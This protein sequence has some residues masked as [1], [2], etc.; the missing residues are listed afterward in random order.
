[1]FV[2]DRRVSLVLLANET[3]KMVSAHPLSRTL[4]VV[5]FLGALMESHC[6]LDLPLG[7]DKIF[8]LYGGARSHVTHHSRFTCN[9]APFFTWMDQIFGTA[10]PCATPRCLVASQDAVQRGMPY[11]PPRSWFWDDLLAIGHN[12][13][14]KSVSNRAPTG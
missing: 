12:V 8:P 5:Y 9:Y 1:L 2:L 13:E 11:Q 3:L 7:A 10:S 14:A 4:F 6:N